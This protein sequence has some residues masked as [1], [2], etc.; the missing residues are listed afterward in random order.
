MHQQNAHSSITTNKGVGIV[1]L[2]LFF[3]MQQVNK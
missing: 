2:F 1:A 3:E